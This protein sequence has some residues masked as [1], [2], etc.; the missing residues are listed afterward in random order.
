[1]QAADD[2]NVICGWGNI[3]PR[4]ALRR[5]PTMRCERLSAGS[6]SC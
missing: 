1:M 6:S 2:D 4:L 5:S 3:V